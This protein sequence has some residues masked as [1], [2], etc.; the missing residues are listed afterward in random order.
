MASRIDAFLELVVKQNGSDLHLVAGN[1]P[2]MRLHGEVIT[3]KYREL[4]HEETE[5]FLYE[6]MPERLHA[7]FEQRNGLDFAYSVP[8]LARFRVNIFRHLGGMGAVFRVVPH[9]VPE[10]EQLALPAVVANFCRFKQGLVLVTGPTGSGKSTTL[11]AMLNHINTHLRGHI[12][13][14]EDPVEFLH[15]RKSCL[16]SQRELG[17]H[18]R[19]FPAALR[20]A[21]REDP[22]VIMVG[23]LRDYESISLALTAAETGVL[24]LATLHTSDAASTVDRMIN[25]FPAA[26]QARI[27]V[28]A[29]SSLVGVVSQRLIRRSDGRGR[30]VA[31]ETLVNN[32]AAANL[33]REGKVE[34]LANVIQSGGLQG[35]Q[36]MDNALRHLLD[37]RLISGRAAYR[38]ASNKAQFEK[39]AEA[40][41]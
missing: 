19:S 28:M 22:D 15:Q 29:A 23:E 26:D 10:L 36:S 27:R 31:I 11:A 41:E 17:F 6:V 25:A 39:Y 16:V 9:D 14:I 30:V 38:V 3:I 1:M 21:L 8:D 35:M 24:V 37:E 34:Q 13:T 2:R 5:N 40:D 32:P 12:I 4:S 33:I 18:T 20:S 7:E